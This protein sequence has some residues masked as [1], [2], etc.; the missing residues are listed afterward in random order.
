M[1]DRSRACVSG[2]EEAGKPLVG[3]A[4]ASAGAGQREDPALQHR[5]GA[6]S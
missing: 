4:A 3:V 1:K 2:R 6:G 5:V